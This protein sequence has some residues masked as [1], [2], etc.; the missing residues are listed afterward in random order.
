MGKITWSP[1]SLRDIELI[2]QYISADSPDRAVLFVSRIIEITERLEQ[3]PSSGRPIPEVDK[4]N[5]R[6]IIY[7]TY[8]IM[9]K[10]EKDQI[11]IL[12][13][14]HSARDWYPE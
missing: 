8:R 5:Y 11:L 3:F 10:I 12:N 1:S 4:Q 7:S 9:Y 2:S 13:V 14:I 6:E